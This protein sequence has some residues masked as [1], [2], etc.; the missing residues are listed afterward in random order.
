MSVPGFPKPQSP[1]PTTTAVSTS[2]TGDS[3][4]APDQ[5]GQKLPTPTMGSRRT[6]VPPN[7]RAKQ[8]GVDSS[9]SSS[10]SS[11]ISHLPQDKSEPRFVAP[12][13]NK[14]DAPARK[15]AFDI[16]PGIHAASGLRHG[17]QGG[18]SAQI[19]LKLVSQNVEKRLKA[20][21][22]TVTG[23]DI[24]KFEAA[25]SLISRMP[26]GPVP[27]QFRQELSAHFITKESAEK[28]KA[29]RIDAYLAEG[30]DFLNAL[31]SGKNAHV[32][33]EPYLW[34]VPMTLQAKGE[35]LAKF[36][37]LARAFREKG[38]ELPSMIVND[39]IEKGNV[40]FLR[41]L[42]AAYPDMS[43]ATLFSSALAEAS[44]AHSTGISGKQRE[45]LRMALADGGRPESEQ[46][47]VKVENLALQTGDAEMMA[48]LLK[49]GVSSKPY[50]NENTA[51]LLH[52][53]ARISDLA[54][55]KSLVEAGLDI[56]ERHW[57]MEGD[58]VLALAASEA[59][60]LPLV[61]YLVE[62]CPGLEKRRKKMEGAQSVASVHKHA[63]INAYLTKALETSTD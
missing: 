27:A 57:S 14:Q 45:I 41:S 25:E 24:A 32:G 50:A 44:K 62:E 53:A 36:F 22:I 40:D 47:R 31:A 42:R 38:V 35:H 48:S 33:V 1:V 49:S 18:V 26:T 17:M 8:K 23:E 21:G 30:K 55:F 6:K 61:K 13:G 10:S 4:A 5:A 39:A 19:H 12:G 54:I 2:P 16:Y 34:L 60:G 15:A 63:A 7:A 56:N 20:Q 59:G 9:S 3:S 29:A 11:A 51:P 37:D 43:F 58:H 28:Y 52:R 46:E